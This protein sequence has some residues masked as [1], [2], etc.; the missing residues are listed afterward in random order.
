[1][2]GSDTATRGLRRIGGFAVVCAGATA[3]LGGVTM[4]ASAAPAPA[5]STLIAAISTIPGNQQAG[6]AATP[7]LM[8]YSDGKAVHDNHNGHIPLDV[9]HSA[10]ADGKALAAKDLGMP[11]DGKGG[12]TLMD[13]LGS[14][15]D[16]DVHLVVYSPG[17]ADGINDAQKAAREKVNA[18]SKKLTDAFVADR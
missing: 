14:S 12:E 7:T 5:S 13:F 2:R 18:L 10:A 15:P 6:I 17:G 11:K 3:L 16:Q 4:P 8:V 9:V 1:M